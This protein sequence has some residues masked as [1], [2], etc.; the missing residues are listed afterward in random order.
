MEGVEGTA[1]ALV[2]SQALKERGMQTERSVCLTFSVSPSNHHLANGNREANTINTQRAELEEA[3]NLQREAQ[4]HRG[5]AASVAMAYGMC[6]RLSRVIEHPANRPLGV[7]A[8]HHHGGYRY[9]LWFKV[10]RRNERMVYCHYHPNIRITQLM[11]MY[12]SESVRNLESQIFWRTG[13]SPAS[14]YHRSNRTLR[15]LVCQ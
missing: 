13:Q 4:M 2:G 1:G 11:W 3:E 10:C 12:S 15:H 8:G 5:R 9:P 6:L 7:N 14:C